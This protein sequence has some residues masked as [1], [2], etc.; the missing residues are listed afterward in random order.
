MVRN[1]KRKNPLPRAPAYTE[2]DVQEALRRVKDGE[3]VNKVA[4]QMSIPRRTLRDRNSGKRPTNVVGRPRALLPGEEDCIAQHA[5][6]LGDYGYAF[7]KME[8]CLF[9]KSYL[10]KAGRDVTQFK[11]NLPGND[12]IDAFLKR[13][14]TL[15]HRVCQNI[16]R[17]R[18]AVSVSEVSAFFDN[19]RESIQ[20]IPPENIL[21]YDETNLTDDPKGKKMIFRKGVKHAERVMNT[22]K[23]SISLMFACTASG[24]VLPPYVVYK[25]ERLMDNWVLG[26]PIHAHYNRSKSGWFDN[27]LFTDWIKKVAI[28]YFRRL[29]EGHPRVLIGDNLSA[30]FG[31]EILDL[32]EANNIKYIFLP[33]NSTGMLQPLDVAVYGPMK[34]AWR[35]ILTQWKKGTGKHYA[36]LPKHAFPSLLYSLLEDMDNLSELA[37]SG[38]RA[39]GIYP[40]N[41]ERIIAKLNQREVP[42]GA[43]PRKIVSP[44]VIEHLRTIREEAAAKPTRPRA[45]RCL[46]EP[47]QSVTIADLTAATS[48]PKRKPTG[49]RKK[50]APIIQDSSSAD[51]PSSEEDPSDQESEPEP[52]EDAS[53]SAITDTA[54]PILDAP[55]TGTGTGTDHLNKGD[56]V[57]VRFPGKGHGKDYHFIGMLLNLVEPENTD[58]DVR[59]FRR[60]ESQKVAAGCVSFKEPENPDIAVT[61]NK[62]IVLK[63][64]KPEFMKGKLVFKDVF[65]EVILR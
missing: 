55:G 59:Y 32:C 60:V 62:Q 58:W 61:A 53:T 17:K 9:V 20:G 51:E 41:K 65:G 35:K 33:A 19:L 63:L 46:A 21:N 1:Y 44:L 26:G 14:P 56:Y 57:L 30:H 27:Y 2:E 24:V 47:G 6:A 3:S 16:C 42:V 52:L 49:T 28:P 48:T 11:D 43:S 50:T 40:L 5:A 18:A 45:K 7:D 39:C 34:T 54:V 64:D 8:L 37:I 36:T 25:G 10:D 22:S 29:P 38:F 12:W 23:T 15:T 13:H 31:A 4:R